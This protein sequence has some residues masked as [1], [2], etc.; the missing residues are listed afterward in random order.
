M[1]FPNHPA[2]GLGDIESL[3]N[4]AILPSQFY[5]NRRSTNQSPVKRLFLA[6]LEDALRVIQYGAQREQWSQHRGTVYGQKQYHRDLEWVGEDSQEP[7]G[8]TNCCE[9]LGIEPESLRKHVLSGA[10]LNFKRRAPVIGLL[11]CEA[12]RVR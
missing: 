7:F 3:P 6:V 9:A 10:D 12:P 1:S 2:M 4:D 5:D 11:A 8:F